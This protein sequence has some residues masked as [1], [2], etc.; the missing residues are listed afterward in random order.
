M[1]SGEWGQRRGGQ[2]APRSEH[3]G[4]EEPVPGRSTVDTVATTLVGQAE[5]RRKR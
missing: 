3:M 4:V 5:R 1:Q 2:E